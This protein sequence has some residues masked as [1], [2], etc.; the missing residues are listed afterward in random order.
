MKLGYTEFSYG[1]AFTENLVR[2]SAKA[3]TSAPFFPN[4]VQEAQ[5]G[6]DVRVDMHGVPLF[7]QFK[8][9]EL[10]V[11]DTAKEISKFHLSRIS[12]KFFRMSLM[13]RDQS[14][15]HVRLIKLGKK[16]SNA[17]FYA[18]PMLEDNTEFND[19]YCTASVHENTAFFSPSKIGPL[20]DSKA[21]SIAYKKGSSAYKKGSSLGWLCSEPKEVHVLTFEKL[22]ILISTQLREREHENLGDCIRQVRKGIDPFLN[23][24]LRQAEAEIRE[25]ILERQPALK[26]EEH[27]SQVLAE[28]LVVR[29]LARVGMGV[30][31]LIAQP[32]EGRMP[33]GDT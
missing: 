9:P 26:A 30:E 16:F 31:F 27:A 24:K 3:P 7:F 14:D 22:Q 11:R 13:R 19:A 15:Q 23:A 28:L 17:V 1:Y 12:T 6:Y 20:P 4:L 18:S 2:S 25:N 29:E 21:H 5:L 33:E 10:M 8:L 32:G